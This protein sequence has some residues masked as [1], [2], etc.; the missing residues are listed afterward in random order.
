MEAAA[1]FRILVPQN[2]PELDLIADQCAGY[3]VFTLS[4]RW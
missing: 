1:R 3:R 2:R 4:A